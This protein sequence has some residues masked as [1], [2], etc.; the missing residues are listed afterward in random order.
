MTRI[1]IDCRFASQG[2]GLGTYTRELVIEL[3][4]Q[5]HFEYVLFVRSM[6]EPWIAHLP[7]DTKIVVANYPHYSFAEQLFFPLLIARQKI[8]LF[9]CPHFNV[10]FF[11]PVPFV[12][13]IHDLILHRFPN[14]ASI[15]KRLAY[16]I[17]MRRSVTKARKIIAVSA[18]TASEIVYFYGKHFARVIEVVT[19]GVSEAFSSPVTDSDI[20][21]K[22]AIPKDFFLYVGNAKQH[23]NVPMLIAAHKESKSPSPLVLICGGVEAKTLQLHE[24]VYLLQNISFEDL[25]LFYAQARC[26][27]TAS[28]YEGFCLP[29]LEA[30][31][32]GCPVIATNRTAIIEIAGANAV[33]VEPTPSDFAHAFQN[34]PTKSD[35]PDAIYSWQS[36]AKITHDLL[37]NTLYG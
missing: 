35:P 2:V 29:V 32:A 3:L 13:T 26:F 15:L 1:G 18:Y 25:P 37:T 7:K 16:R 9:F 22:Y 23:K 27:V 19:E 30:R 6:D 28:L 36:A 33:L 34:P 21:T 4:A 8:D 17:L 20:C 11:C 14:Q 10:P 12:V 31:K 5:G 24:N